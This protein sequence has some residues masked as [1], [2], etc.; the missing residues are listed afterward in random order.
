MQLYHRGDSGHVVAHV[1][2]VLAA[3]GLPVGPEA[4]VAVTDFDLALDKAVRTFQQQRGLSVDGIVGPDTL[5]ALDEARRR[6]GDRLLYFSP[7]RPFVGDDVAEL[8]TRLLNMGFD[9]GRCDGIF[10]RRTE[11]ALREFQRNRGLAADGR[12]GPATLRE[13]HRLAR[14]VV[15]GRPHELRETE[16]LRRRGQGE[17]VLTVAIDAGHG[18]S[19]AGWAVLGLC[20]RDIVAEIAARLEG[21]LLATGLSAFLTH[22]HNES[23]DERERARRANELGADVMISLHVDAAPSPRCQG[24]ATFHFGSP[25]AV[26]VIGAKFAELVQRE[27]VSRTDLVDLRTHPRTWELLRRTQM[28][29]VRVELGYLTNPQ[30]AACLAAPE[31]RDTV[32]EALLAAVQRLFL[33]PELDPPT[34]QL[35]LP[36]VSLH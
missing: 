33:P 27:I 5:R 3:L 26:S 22:A 15:G 29:T 17:S 25:R 23:P 16:E 4:G 8:Q 32:A 28:P 6:L 21:R 35:R 14:V 20:E 7:S 13:L 11:S 9:A 31:F 30:D 18:G 12:C 36:A 34:G 1:R 10:G 2:S 19:D 24:V